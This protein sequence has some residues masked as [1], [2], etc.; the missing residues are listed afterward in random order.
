MKMCTSRQKVQVRSIAKTI[1]DESQIEVHGSLRIHGEE[2]EMTI[3]VRVN[4]DNDQVTAKA[5]FTVPYVSCGM[6]D[7][8]NLAARG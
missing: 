1:L 8:S 3:P 6:K 2:H 4:A 7:P 5:K